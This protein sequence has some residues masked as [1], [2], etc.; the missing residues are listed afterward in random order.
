MDLGQAEASAVDKADARSINPIDVHLGRR[1]RQA[2]SAIGLTQQQ[3]A[4]RLGVSVQQLQKYERGSNR[5]SASRLYQ[6]SHVLDVSIPW[7]FEGLAGAEHENPNSAPLRDDADIV[8]FV[9]AVQ[10][11][12]KGARRRQLQQLALVLADSS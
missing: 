11:I 5:I 6:M 9:Q 10:K 3:F 8:R 1:L 2:R 12:P 4:D 7:F